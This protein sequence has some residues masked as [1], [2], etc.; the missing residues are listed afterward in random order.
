[1]SMS[2]R[3][4]LKILDEHE[5]SL[6]SVSKCE[7]SMSKNFLPTSDIQESAHKGYGQ[8]RACGT[9]VQVHAGV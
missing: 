2:L 1:M 7:L 6:K 9:A 4:S 3:I 5:W 8:P